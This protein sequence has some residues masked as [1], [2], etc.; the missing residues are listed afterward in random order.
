MNKIKQKKQKKYNSINLRA[1]QPLIEQLNL[2]A[3][4][5]G[6]STATYIKEFIS[7]RYCNYLD[8]K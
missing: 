7:D 8:F 4:L 5:D 6:V 2:L 3:Q 1:S